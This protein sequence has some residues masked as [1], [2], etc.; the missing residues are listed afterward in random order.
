M[1]KNIA[2]FHHGGTEARRKTKKLSANERES[3]QKTRIM[4]SRPTGPGGKHQLVLCL[5][6]HLR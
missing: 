2:A 3:G 1:R 5:G 4:E 6:F